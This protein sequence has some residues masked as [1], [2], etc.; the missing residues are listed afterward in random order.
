V[1]NKLGIVGGGQL[2]RMMAL[3]A[4]PLGFVVTVLDPSE[5]C[6]ASHCSKQLLGSF[7]DAGSIE[8]LACEVD[9]VTF[10]IESANAAAMEKLAIEGKPLNPH[11]RMLALIKDKY[12]QK[13]FYQQHQIPCA[14]SCQVESKADIIAAG[15]KFNY[16]LL[17]KARF[18]AYDGRGNALVRSEAGI[19]AAIEKLGE[20]NLY[21]EQFVPFEKELAVVVAR[22]VHGNICSYPVVET[23]HENNI[24]HTVLCPAPVADTI[25]E[26]ATQF[27]EQLVS[28]LEG[29]GVFAVE[30]F[31][32]STGDVLVNEVAPRVH[33]SGHHTIEACVTSQFEQHVRA[34]T[35]L[36]LGDAALKVPAAV[37]LNILGDRQGSADIQGLDKA[38]AIEGV[39]VHFYGKHETKPERKMGHL[40]AIG[41][42]LEQALHNANQARELISI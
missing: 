21:V 34:V 29:A 4:I 36:P 7:K 16:P 42:T 3:A 30:L 8:Q 39:S 38:L 5:N 6:P 15:E 22:D 26:K 33:N 1:K 35:G 19:E 12:R 37:M 9:Y 41:E 2:G 11:P 40:T 14:T 20:K 27:A 10:E 28:H 23:I 31:L 25:K 32:T 24:C 13:L 17:L 18:D